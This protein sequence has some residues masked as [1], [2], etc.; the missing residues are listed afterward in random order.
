MKAIDLVL[1]VLKAYDWGIRDIWN[2]HAH[3]DYDSFEDWQLE[4]LARALAIISTYT[5]QEALSAL[6]SALRELEH[7]EDTEEESDVADVMTVT[8]FFDAFKH[9]KKVFGEMAAKMSEGQYIVASDLAK[10]RIARAAI[11]DTMPECWTELPTYK[12]ERLSS[13]AQS[14]LSTLITEAE[15]IVSEQ[16]KEDHD[17][18]EPARS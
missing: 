6:K 4:T 12:L 18:Q 7:R 17:G 3:L 9:G 2:L 13:G 10:L 5:A 16:V 11:A 8:E 15:R 1:G 14:Q